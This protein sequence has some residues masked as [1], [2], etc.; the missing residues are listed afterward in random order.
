MGENTLSICTLLHWFNRF[1]SGNFELN[2]SRHS[3]R[4]LEVDVDVL[5]QFIE[6][7]PRLTTCCLAERL[8]RSHTTVETHL[9]EIR[10][11][12]E[13]WS[14]DTISTSTQG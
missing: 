10:Q 11:D 2:D 12:M 4:L 13:I 14:L 8:G 5:K 7:D 3:R 1:K 6:E 9:S